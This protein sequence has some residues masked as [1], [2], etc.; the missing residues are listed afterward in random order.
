SN[1]IKAAFAL[2]KNGFPIFQ[3][4]PE[5]FDASYAMLKYSFPNLYVSTFGDTGRAYQS[6]ETLEIG[7]AIATK[8][9][10]PEVPGMMAAINALMAQGLYKR[11][12]AGI[13]GLLAYLPSLPEVENQ[14]YS[15][16][17]S[18]KLDFA[19]F[20]LQRNGT[21]TKNGMMYGVQGSSYN[22]N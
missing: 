21:D 7:L 17:R 14:P 1:L 5:L 13:L 9:H 6:P 12:N 2:E 22:H 3:K 20:F 10:R 4:Y 19:R 16:P 15:W 11:S 18:G 8:H